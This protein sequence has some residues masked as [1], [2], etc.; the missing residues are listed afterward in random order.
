VNGS[1]Q[2]L[3]CPTQ[4]VSREQMA[5]FLMRAA[6]QTQLAS[7]TPTFADV[8]SSSPFYGWIE[9]LYEQGVTGGCGV[10]G[11]GQP[12]FCPTQLVSRGQMATFL[13]RT[14]AAP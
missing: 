1:G 4:L 7:P 13:I 10:N 12:L 9:R 8:P 3:F 11:S 2:P 6:G 14:F 5:V